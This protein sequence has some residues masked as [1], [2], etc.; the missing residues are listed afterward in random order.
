MNSSST[1]M[2]KE[3]ANTAEAIPGALDPTVRAERIR[4]FKD[5]L[6]NRIV[7]IDGAMGTMIQ[8]HELDE[9]AFRG[10][11]FADHRCPV[12]GNND[13]LI[14]TQPDLIRDLHT[15]YLNAG[16]DVLETNTFSSTRVAQADYMMEDAVFDLNRDGARL[17]REAADAVTACD[18]TRPRFVAGVLGPTNR[19]ASISPDVNDPGFRNVKF[20]ELVETYSEA[21][22]GLLEGGADVILVETVFDT[23]NCKAAL[24]AIDSVVEDLAFEVPVMISGTITDQSG[25]TLTGQTT[26][27]F[28]N[29]I[30]HAKPISIGLN[31]ALGPKDLRPYVEELSRIADTFVSCHPNAGLL[32]H[33]VG[34][35]KRRR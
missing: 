20:D 27:G 17:A 2:L 1:T 9:V 35:M 14:L 29:S 15:A 3:T 28:W 19:T 32:M 26:E 16:V 13:L 6:D 25:R 12:K 5:Q 24:F 7:I 11:R 10:D 4:Q 21:V 23:L 31:C 22:L 30:R 8:D 33:L 18:E 34:M